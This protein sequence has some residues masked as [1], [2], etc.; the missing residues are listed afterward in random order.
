MKTTNKT[1]VVKPGE[2]LSSIAAQWYGSAAKWPTLASANAI[3]APYTLRVGQI[4]LVPVALDELA[5]VVPTVKYVP[6]IDP[7]YPVVE[8]D[9]LEINAPPINPLLLAGIVLIG[10]TAY[11]RA[12]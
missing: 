10:I 5:P 7:I 2:S 11:N 1:H 8:L 12:R 9:A 6:E 3:S 4:L